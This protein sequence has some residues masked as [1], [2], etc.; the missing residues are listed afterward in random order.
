MSF[1]R[2]MKKVEALMKDFNLLTGRPTEYIQPNGDSSIGYAYV[3][4]LG[5]QDGHRCSVGII[6]NKG[7]G[8]VHVHGLTYLPIGD[9]SRILRRKMKDPEW[10]EQ[11]RFKPKD[12]E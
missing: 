12:T 1:Q 2:T 11:M 10:M 5:E 9:L 3:R 8:L 4:N 7:G 6:F